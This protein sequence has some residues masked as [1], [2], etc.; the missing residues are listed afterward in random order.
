MLESD[1]GLASGTDMGAALTD[2]N[3][4]DMG[5]ATGAR[6]TRTPENFQL[7][8]IATPIPGHRIKIRL[9]G[10]EGSAEICKPAL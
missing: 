9:T 10:S 1:S 3:A 5:F 6:Q 8:L 7:I 2:D 4:F